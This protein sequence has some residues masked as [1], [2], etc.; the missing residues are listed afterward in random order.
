VLLVG[1]DFFPWTADHFNLKISQPVGLF[2]EKF[3]KATKCYYA[4]CL[5][6]IIYISSETEEGSSTGSRFKG[7]I[8]K[9]EYFLLIAGYLLVFDL[10]LFRKTLNDLK[11]Y[12][13]HLSVVHYSL[14]RLSNKLHI[15]PKFYKGFRVMPCPK[16]QFTHLRIASLFFQL[17]GAHKRTPVRSLLM[18][19]DQNRSSCFHFQRRKG[20]RRQRE[21]I[22][23]F[24]L[25]FDN[26]MSGLIFCAT[27]L[28][29]MYTS[30]LQM[31][32]CVE[33]VA[34]WCWTLLIKL[35]THCDSGIM[36]PGFSKNIWSWWGYLYRTSPNSQNSAI[37]LA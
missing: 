20:G 32:I 17:A 16:Q 29:A 30:A 24:G 6:S 21:K 14:L 13:K 1:C 2:A 36:C 22:V 23:V 18:P 7:T 11:R 10:A 8:R 5:E 37:K 25:E 27:K 35:D 33:F 19:P 28:R 26:Q 9:A 12:V 34:Q 15:L 4:Y 31:W 3:V